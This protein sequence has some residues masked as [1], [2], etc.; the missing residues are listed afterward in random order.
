MNESNSVTIGLDIGTTSVK[1]VAADSAGSVIASTRIEHPAL[2]PSPGVLE[3]DADLAWRE[4]ARVAAVEVGAG[5]VSAGYRVAGLNVAAMVPSLCAVDVA[6]KPV[7]PGLLYGDRR[8]VAAAEAAGEPSGRGLSP[9]EDG[10]FLRMLRWLANEYPD[11]AGYWPAQAVANASL[12][13]TG[14]LD[15]VTAMTTLPVFDFTGWDAA[16]CESVGVD[17]AQ[18][19]TIAP[20]STAVGTVASGGEFDPD[21]VLEGAAVGGGVI[22]AFA[23]QMVA[24]ADSVG[25][26]LVIVGATLI[27]WACIDEWKEFPG[28]WTVPHSVE[29]LTLV[30]GPSNAGGIAKNWAEAVLLPP[31]SLDGG[32]TGVS[33]PGISKPGIRNPWEVPVFLPH[34]RGERVPLH[35]VERRGG[36]AGLSVAQGPDEMWRS[37]YEASG[38][39]IRRNLDLA[40]LLPA[41]ARRIVAT[42]GGSAD[43][44]WMQAV[45]DATGLPVHTVAEPKGAALGSA[46]VA[47]AACG[48]EDGIG[49]A[50]RWSGEGPVFEPDPRWVEACN[51]RYELFVELSGAPF[52]PSAPAQDPPGGPWQEIAS[53]TSSRDRT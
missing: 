12:C 5:A 2:T 3:H 15:T 44:H 21:G 25:D 7:S 23:E 46:Y 35:D 40:D 11:A 49:D 34:V 19:P 47:R 27:T 10:E 41:T 42:G 45:A 9:A 4:G 30:G 24:G 22:D 13:G 48:L 8:A 14:A 28:L 53:E 29:G 20:G 51:G 16:V 31:S 33:K 36:F 43:P 52:D 38:F 17:P 32:G 6:G 26:V 18:L 39:T 1:A 37:V 50:G